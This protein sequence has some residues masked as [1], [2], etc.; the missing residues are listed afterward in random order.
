MALLDEDLK[1]FLEGDVAVFVGTRTMDLKPEVTM[2]WGLKVLPGF[3]ELRLFVDEAAGAKVLENLNDNRFMAVTCTSP[4]SLRSVQLKGW[5]LEI[6]EAEP[7]DIPRL[8]QHRQAFSES[9]RAR[10][11]PAHVTRTMWSNDVKRLKLLVQDRFDQTPG[12][13]AGAR[14]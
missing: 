4:I 3:Q 14:G 7:E 9:A 8:A 6:D 5:C 13:G 12:P 1:T 10:G 11:F 2:G